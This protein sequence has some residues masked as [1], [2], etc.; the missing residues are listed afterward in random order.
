M[1]HKDKRFSITL[2]VRLFSYSGEEA[3][4]LLALNSHVLQD[5]MNFEDFWVSQLPHVHTP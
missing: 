3:V 4:V 2:A 1:I 5:M